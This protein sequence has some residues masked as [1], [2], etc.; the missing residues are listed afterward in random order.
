MIIIA[1]SGSTKTHWCLMAANGQSSEFF[2]DGINPF[3]QTQDAMRNSVVN[4]LLPQMGHLMWAG[5]V[6]KVFFYGAGCTPEKSPFVMRALQGVFRA[7]EV[8]VESD[9]VGAARGLL[10]HKKGV[11]CILGTG[12]NSCLYDGEQIVR[13]VPSLGFIL[14]DEGGGAVLGKRLV[15]DIF[16]N[17]LGSELKEIF[18]QEYGL[19]QADVIEHVY[20]QPFPNRYL[21]SLSKFCANHID[22]K[23][24]YDLVYDHFTEFVVRNLEQYYQDENDIE[25]EDTK[26]LPVGFIGGIAYYYRPVLQQVLD[27]MGFT[28]STIMIDPIEGLKEYHRS[29]ITPTQE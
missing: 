26:S 2:T 10:Q 21:A 29:D 5:T 25:I 6:N 23:R 28:L 7:A 22:N 16:K 4:Q 17:Q 24:I 1:D 20:R 18:L 11:A 15:A 27:D 3:Y 8:M 9:I 14:G 12:S 19:T 13:N